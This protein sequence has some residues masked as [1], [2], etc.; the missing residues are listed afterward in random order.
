[1]KEDMKIMKKNKFTKILLYSILS[2]LIAII[3]FLMI[4]YFGKG[5]EVQKNNSS[6]KRIN[7]EQT[8]QVK[9]SKENQKNNSEQD[10]ENENSATVVQESKENQNT[11][12]KQNKNSVNES[13]TT[14]Q[15]KDY[16]GKKLSISEGLGTTGKVFKSQK[17]ALEFGKQEIKRLAEGDKKSRQFSISKVT[18]EDG[19][20]VGWTVD[21]FEDN[22]VEKVVSNPIE[23]SAEKNK[24]KE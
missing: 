22:S 11:S 13:Q 2:C 12:I 7:Q 6:D 18:A 24:D 10:K 1:M 17:E 16:K 21:V 20:L 8:E 9:D 19:S 4:S 15:Q 14:N 5:E 3:I 23:N